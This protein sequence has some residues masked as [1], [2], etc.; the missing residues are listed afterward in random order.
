MYS[1]D[2]NRPSPGG[3]SVEMLINGKPCK[4][5]VDTAADY[6]IMAHSVYL[7]KFA[8][9]PLTPSKVVLRTYTGE[10]LE[11]SGEMQCNVVYKDKHYSLPVVVVDYS[12]KP[13]L[14]GKNW[15]RQI[16]LAWGETL[17][18][19]NENP[20]SAEGQLSNLLSKYHELFS[21]SY[22][23]MKGLEAHITMKSNVIKPIFVK[24]R[25]VPYALKVQVEKEL[26]KLETH[27]VIKKTDK[28]NWASPIVVMPKSDNTVRICGDY[29][30]TIN[31][32]VDYEPYV[33]PTTQDLYTALVGSKVFSTLDLSHAY[34]QLN[35]DKERQ[36]YLTISTHKGLYSYLKLTYGVKSSPKIFQAKMDQILQGIEKCVCKQDDILAGGNDW[37][38]NLI[39]KILA[40]VL[41]R[42][43]KYNLRLKLPKCEFF[44]PEVVYLGLKISAVG[45]QPVEEKINA[46]KKAPT[47]RNVSELRSF[48]G[49]VQYYYSFL[50]GLATMLASLHIL[51]FCKR[52]S[53]GSGHTTARK[54]LKPV[55]RA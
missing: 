1:L 2:T 24:A 18:V 10:A 43:H 14:L 3:Y 5:E 42:L 54:L 29:K 49:M 27:G 23:G 8:D 25:R 6:S 30:A 40:E 53:S 13:T 52:A 15:L 50:P 31:Q 12:A 35:V 4:M 21:D 47:P 11:V 26:D 41:D 33:L 20:V 9:T 48:L 16:K 39:N 28:S 17:S 36:E 46:V 44:K 51:S 32:F 7:E 55:R 34:A 19:S 37:Q 22:E 38:E 45:L